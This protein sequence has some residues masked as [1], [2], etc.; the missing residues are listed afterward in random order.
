VD[1]PLGAAR[2]YASALLSAVSDATAAARLS[3]ELDRL[4]DVVSAPGARLLLDDPRATVPSRVTALTSAAGGTVTP[5]VIALLTML[6][7]RRQLISVPAIAVAVREALDLRNGITAARVSSALDL[8]EGERASIE[9]HAQTIAGGAVRVAYTVDE[10]LVGGVTLRVGDR[11]VDG[12][13]K[14]RLARMR[15]Q[16]LSAAG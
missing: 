16:I 10:S 3:S 9:K 5:R 1:R 14:G 2:R 6:A 13:V 4:A 15:E 11:L 7:R 12:S 8:G